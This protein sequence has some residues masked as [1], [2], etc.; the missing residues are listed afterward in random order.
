MVGASGALATPGFTVSVN[1]CVIG[2]LLP[3]G[4]ASIV[5]IWVPT[6]DSGGV[7]DMTPSGLMRS[8]LMLEPPWM[9]YPPFGGQPTWVTWKLNSMQ[10]VAVDVAAEIKL[11]WLTPGSSTTVSG[12]MAVPA[13][14]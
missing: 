13:L 9:E 7:P 3:C 11:G 8:Q 6:E 4:V 1:V 5:K 14:F 10:A 2:V 12:S